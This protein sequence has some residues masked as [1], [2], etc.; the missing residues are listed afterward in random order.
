MSRLHCHPDRAQIHELDFSR[1]S[2]VLPLASSLGSVRVQLLGVEI[3]CGERSAVAESSRTV[4]FPIV[5]W[6]IPRE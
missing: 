2:C 5:N 3:R 6:D 1:Q 4:I